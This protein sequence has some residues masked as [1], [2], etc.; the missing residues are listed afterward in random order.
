MFCNFLVFFKVLDQWYVIYRIEIKE[1]IYVVMDVYCLFG[2]LILSIIGEYYFGVV[3]NG[4]VEVWFSESENWRIVIQIVFV[5][6]L[7]KKFEIYKWEF[8]FFQ[9]QI[10]FG[11]FLEV[12]VRY[13]IEILYVLGILNEMDNF[14]QVIWK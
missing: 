5:M 3:L 12:R 14:F 13:Y 9:I 11:I 4:F 7:C 1:L 6:F 10:L 2:F 8:N